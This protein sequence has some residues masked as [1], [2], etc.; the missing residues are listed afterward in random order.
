MILGIGAN[1]HI[2]FNEPAEALVARTHLVTLDAPTRAANALW[3]GGDV[4]QVPRRALTM[5][6]ATILGAR[7]IVLIATGEAKAD[8]VR[9]HARWGRHDAVPASF[10]QLHPQVSVMLDQS[11]A[12]QLP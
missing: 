6:M 7:A 3:F 5:G 10:L 1:G 11:L 9:A 4:L 12:D 2:G 8:A